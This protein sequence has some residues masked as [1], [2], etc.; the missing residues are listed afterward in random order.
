MP[1][2]FKYR[3]ALR[4]ADPLHNDMLDEMPF[5]VARSGDNRMQRVTK[6]LQMGFISQAEAKAMLGTW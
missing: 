5:W 2:W 4:A 3:F 1:Q 6:M